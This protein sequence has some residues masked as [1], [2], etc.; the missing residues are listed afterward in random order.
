MTNY[1]K[2]RPLNLA[3]DKQTKVIEKDGEG[4]IFHDST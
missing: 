1:G 4:R 3:L 2:F